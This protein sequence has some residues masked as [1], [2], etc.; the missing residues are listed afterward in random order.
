[1]IY[2]GLTLVEI[3]VVT[4]IVAAI[5]AI[6]LPVYLRARDSGHRTTCLSNVRQITAATL[7]YM[8][9]WRHPPFN[10]SIPYS[11]LSWLSAV[12]LADRNGP[13][14]R[15]PSHNPGFRHEKQT[16]DS[17]G[18]GVNGCLNAYYQKEPSDPSRTVLITERA[19]IVRR[20]GIAEDDLSSEWPGP[21]CMYF[22]EYYVKLH[23]MVMLT[24]YACRRHQ[25]GAHYGMLDGRAVWRKPEQIRYWDS[26][27]PCNPKRAGKWVGPPDG[28]TFQL[29][30]EAGN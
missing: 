3:L 29:F 14:L 10:S 24:G 15:C 28:I 20:H 16:R 11:T 17:T 4:A 26:L 5:S 13:H 30:T 6:A 8:E 9:E 27:D 18:Y 22:K 7:M 1:M 2:G 19:S 12:G 23:G 21:D 25:G